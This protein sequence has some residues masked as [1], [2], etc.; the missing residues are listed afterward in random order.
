MDRRIRIVAITRLFA[1]PIAV[2]VKAFRAFIDGAVAVVIDS[3]ANLGRTRM[4]PGVFV[5][6]VRAADAVA[7]AVLIV[8][9]TRPRGTSVSAQSQSTEIDFGGQ[10]H[11]DI[12]PDLFTGLGPK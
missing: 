9:V 1:P 2:V 7:V 8:Q 12:G 6:A 5:I 10:G 11:R 4:R 3:V